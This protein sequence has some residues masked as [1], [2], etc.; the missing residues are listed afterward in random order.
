M[1]LAPPNLLLIG[2]LDQPAFQGHDADKEISLYY[3]MEQ[4][5]SDCQITFVLPLVRGRCRGQRAKAVL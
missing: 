1:E 5:A 3:V 2:N 4:N